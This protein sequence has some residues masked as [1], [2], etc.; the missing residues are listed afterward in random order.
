MEYVLQT[1]IL[2]LLISI[3]RNSSAES[4]LRSR[5]TMISGRLLCKENLLTLIDESGVK[6]VFSAI[7]ERISLLESQ[8]TDEYEYE[9][10]LEALGQ[11]GSC[12]KAVILA[13]D[14]RISLL[15]SQDIDEYECALEALGQ[16]GSCK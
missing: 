10:A 3:I 5:A 12:V 16:I 8:D 14:E 7:D 13:I 15:E 6:A 2:Q 11:I 9:C 4:M 1:N